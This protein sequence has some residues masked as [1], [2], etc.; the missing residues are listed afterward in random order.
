MS[1]FDDNPFG[2]P[3]VDNPFA[4]G[5]FCVTL[6]CLV[7]LHLVVNFGRNRKRA[8]V[9]F[10]SKHRVFVH[11]GW[12]GFFVCICVFWRSNVFHTAHSLNHSH[13]AH[14]YRCVVSKCGPLQATRTHT[15]SYNILTH[16]TQ[17]DTH[18]TDSVLF[19][20][21]CVRARSVGHGA[22]F[23]VILT[24]VWHKQ[25]KKHRCC[26]CVAPSCHFRFRGC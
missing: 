3:M 9:F 11:R 7:Y 26:R 16:M 2:E 25:K 22:F 5:F 8:K 12:G 18:F 13:I 19:V 14:I 1:K 24:H 15:Y 4:V 10:A 21:D 20:C 17:T 6:L 23:C